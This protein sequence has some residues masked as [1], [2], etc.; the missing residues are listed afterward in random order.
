LAADLLNPGDV[1]R[2]VEGSDV[3]YLT[4]GLEYNISIWEKQ[5]PIVMKNVLDACTA[6]SAKLV[7]FDN[8]Y[9]IRLRI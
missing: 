3:V 4:A 8:V 5:W 1:M 2:A 9:S 6:H 7:F